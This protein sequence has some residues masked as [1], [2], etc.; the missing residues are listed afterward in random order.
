M[1]VKSIM[2]PTIIMLLF[3][4]VYTI[5]V[6]AQNSSLYIS[7]APLF[8]GKIPINSSSSMSLSILNNSINSVNISSISIDGDKASKFVITNNPNTYSLTP[9]EGLILN[10]NYTPTSGGRDIAILKIQ[11]GTET[12]TDSLIGYGSAVINGVPTFERV[13]E[14]SGGLDDV[15]PGLV[16]QTSDSGYVIVGNTT[17]ASQGAIRPDAYVLKTDKYGKEEWAKLYG[18]NSLDVGQDVLALDDG[19]TVIVGETESFTMGDPM[20]IYLFKIDLQGNLLWQKDFG[21][22]FEDNANRIIKANDGGFI[23]VGNTITTTY[24]S[25]DAY[26]VKTDTDGNIQWS[27]SYGGQY[28]ENAMDIAPTSDGNY[29]FVGSYQEGQ[30]SDVLIVKIDPSGNELWSKTLSTPYSEQGN[31]IIETTDGGFIIAGFTTGENA[32]DGLLLKINANGDQQWKKAY[33]GIHSDYFSSA[34]KTSD[35]G[36]LCAGATNQYFSKEFV[37]NDLWL[38]KTDSAGNFIWEKKYGGAFDDFAT[39]IIKTKE[40][41]YVI[42][43]STQSFSD[44]NQVYFIG[45]NPDGNIVTDVKKIDNKVIPNKL[46]LFQNYPN[47]FNPSTIIQFD[48]PSLIN[49]NSDNV[50]LRIYDILGNKIATLVNKNL[51]PG[52]YNVDFNSNNVNGKKLSSGIYFYRLIIGNQSATK[53]MVLLK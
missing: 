46:S 51:S 45:V 14:M 21:G 15:D 53:K 12:T 35:G 32:R 5:N 41:G 29:I 50:S 42:S 33:G 47:P 31:S 1:N 3:I 2:K 8:M 39:G 4:T 10:I 17:L 20:Q 19:S 16:A 28:G 37:Y 22:P 38:V 36:Y 43:G 23:I 48:V 7:P 24:G 11:T 26:V 13:F 52:R 25:T 34:V 9:L 6:Q 40:G 44:K 30:N 18:G 49:Q 27:N